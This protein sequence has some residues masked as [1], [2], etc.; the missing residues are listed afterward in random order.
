MV[1][2][3]GGKEGKGRAVVDEFGI[4]VEMVYHF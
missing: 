2:G 3:G 4:E 1:R